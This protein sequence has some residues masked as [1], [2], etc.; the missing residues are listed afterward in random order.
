MTNDKKKDIMKPF[1][2][3][4]LSKLICLLSSLSSYPG[5]ENTKRVALNHGMKRPF[6]GHSLV[7]TQSRICLALKSFLRLGMRQQRLCRSMTG[8]GRSTFSP[9]NILLHKCRNIHHNAVIC[10]RVCKNMHALSQRLTTFS[11]K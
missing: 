1:E 7:F 5:N 6:D 9:Y 3:W 4:P 10:V 2:G 11:K 8:I